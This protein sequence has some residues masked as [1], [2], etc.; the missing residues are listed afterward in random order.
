[1]IRK[2]TGKFYLLSQQFDNFNTVFILFSLR[3]IFALFVLKIVSWIA[4]FVAYGTGTLTKAAYAIDVIEALSS[5]LTFAIFVCKTNIWN[6]F[7]KKCPCLGRLENRFPNYTK[8]SANRHS[9][10]LTASTAVSTRELFHLDLVKTLSR[11]R[12]I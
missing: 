2:S 5:V 9:N 12:Q 10:T 8:Q 1:M 11:S 7:K 6:F 4:E 3:V